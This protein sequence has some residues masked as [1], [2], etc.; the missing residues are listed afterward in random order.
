MN[1][2]GIYRITNT[3]NGKI[4]IGSSVN[5]TE[6]WYRHKRLLRKDAHHNKHLQNAWNKYG[7]S[8][9]TFT[10]IENCEVDNLTVREQYFLNTLKPQYN[11]CPTAGSSLGW[12]HSEETK[13]HLSKVGMGN[14][15]RYNKN[16]GVHLKKAIVGGDIEYSSITEACK[17]LGMKSISNRLIN[18]LKNGTVY[19]NCTW[20]YK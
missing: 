6:R 18:A 16:P 19:R 3:I 2:S 8:E 14:K 15:N 17:Q 1:K 13:R 20:R 9:F 7:E 4:Y 11:I 5:I 12:K 10:I